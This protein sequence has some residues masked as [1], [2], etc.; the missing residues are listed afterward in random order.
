MVRADDFHGDVLFRHRPQIHVSAHLVIAPAGA[1]AAHF[2]RRLFQEGKPDRL[3]RQ[4]VGD[5]VERGSENQ[6]MSLAHF[7]IHHQRQA[8]GQ[9]RGD[10]SLG[11]FRRRLQF[12]VL[13]DCHAV[14]V[15]RL[16]E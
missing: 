3:Q 13:E 16:A 14:P 6:H 10:T 12:Y 2:M 15:L 9:A 1:D 4:V 7:A 11:R 5:V 8:V